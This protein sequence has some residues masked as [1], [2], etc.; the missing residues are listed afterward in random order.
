MRSSRMFRVATM[1]M[2]SG[3]SWPAG[4]FRVVSDDWRGDQSGAP[5]QRRRDSAGPRCRRRL[6]RGCPVGPSRTIGARAGHAALAA[7]GY[8][9]GRS[10][11]LR[12]ADLAGCR[13]RRPSRQCGH[14]AD[15]SHRPGHRGGKHA[16]TGLF[17]PAAETCGLPHRPGPAA[18]RAGAGL[19]GCPGRDAHQRDRGQ[20]CSGALGCAARRR[21]LAHLVGVVDRRCDGRAGRRTVSARPSQGAVATGCGIVA[22]G[23]G[24]CPVARHPCSRAPGDGRR[25]RIPALPRL[26]LPDLGRVPLRTCRC[27]VVRARS[28]HVGDSG[29]RQ[30]GRPIRPQGSFH[31]HGDSPG[32]QRRH[33][34]HRAAARGGHHRAEPHPRGDQAALCAAHGDGGG[35]AGP[36]G[37]RSVADVRRP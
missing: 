13:A 5:A 36:P 26:P 28:L 8:R 37:D 23:R 30:W 6:L 27:R 11:R 9:R 10:A 20:Q 35:H 1:E 4:P 31:Q 12:T 7:H 22:M 15:T 24:G 17:L 33:G 34:T 18:R 21:F 3:A 32:L 29:R 16:R 19:P 2:S 25:Q 14:R